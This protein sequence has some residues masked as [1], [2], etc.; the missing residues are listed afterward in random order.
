MRILYQRSVKQQLLKHLTNFVVPYA[1][2]GQNKALVEED[3]VF[4]E[5]ALLEVPT[6]G[7]LVE[8]FINQNMAVTLGGNNLLKSISF[9]KTPCRR[10]EA[11]DD[12]SDTI[13]DADSARS[14]SA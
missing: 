8:I 10:I 6:S 13:K 12:N 11:E 7:T 1:Y 9:Q 4:D 14:D 5:I 2:H 3:E